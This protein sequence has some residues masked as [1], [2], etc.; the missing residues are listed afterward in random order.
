VEV[1]VGVADDEEED[2][3]DEEDDDDDDVAAAVGVDEDDEDED[4]AAFAVAVADAF[5]EE[6]EDDVAFAVGVADDSDVDVVVAVA[7]VVATVVAVTVAVVVASTVGVT[8]T[9]GVV[10]EA[11]TAA[12][13]RVDAAGAF[14]EPDFS[15]ISGCPSVSVPFLRYVSMVNDTFV[16]DSWLTVPP[17]ANVTRSA[18]LVKLARAVASSSPIVV[19]I[20]TLVAFDCELAVIV[21]V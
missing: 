13:D 5:D 15:V 16:I 1:A 7:V 20:E 19:L 8:V 3:E 21:N 10:N 2:D 14:R 6:V 9:V 18:L 17:S 11:T 12:S 4:D